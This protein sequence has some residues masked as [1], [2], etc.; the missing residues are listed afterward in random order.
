M[1]PTSAA[2]AVPLPE[3]CDALIVGAGFAGLYMLHKL[4]QLGFDA[5]VVEAGSGVGGTWY[6]NRY[7]GARCDIES[8]QYS[9]AFDRELQQDWEW[10][11]RYAAQPE[12]LRYAEH[13][14]D[15]FALRSGITLNTRVAGADLDEAD[16]S[17]LVR[18]GC[19]AVLRTRYLIAAVGCLSTAQVPPWPGA[20]TFGGQ[21]Y[22]TGAWP[23]EGVDLRGKRVG[24][25]GTGSSGIQ[26]I[27]QL[28][29]HAEH[30][31]VFQRTATYTIPARNRPLRPG[32]LDELKAR[33]PE[34]RRAA[35]ASS[36]G[37]MFTT[38]GRPLLEDPPE[39]QQE[40]LHRYW[41][42][43]GLDIARAYTD[44]PVDRTANAVAS[45]FIRARIAELV[46]DPVKRELLTPRT[47][48]FNSRRPC[49][50][51][52][53]F[54]TFNRPNV[55]LV[56]VRT[57]P[58]VELTPTGLRTESAKHDLDVIV[59]ATGYDAMTGTLKRLNVRG[60]DGLGLADAWADQ[61]STYLGL[62]VH[63]FPNFF[64]LA[65]PGSPSVMSNVVLAIEQ[66]VEWLGDL[67]AHARAVGADEVEAEATAQEAWVRH[68]NEVAARSMLF[69]TDSWYLS[70]NVAGRPRV[71][72]P[73][74]G[75]ADLYRRT[76][77][78]VAADGYRGLRIE[79]RGPA[80]VPAQATERVVSAAG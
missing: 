77:E 9:Y 19:G 60:R 69:D 65:G 30:L 80:E 56:D 57:D 35:R 38:E 22:H 7:P 75:G 72:L 8:V 29:E 17:W 45:E 68:S 74:C 47:Y 12:I 79:R 33:Y 58:I 42:M 40:T 78:E 50:D 36:N 3:S 63:G 5:H 15:R 27:P 62:T 28:A 49:L 59:F 61:P 51:T 13:V 14:A 44:V 16:G 41:D 66:H 76:C 10:S 20:E 37:R 53:Y 34:I 55:D 67:L 54:E 21:T 11:E 71:A 2:P 70:A 23:H 24:V 46:I 25:I 6:W 52:N 4:R 73:Y 32:E 18:T 43:G 64:A 39:L 26:I 31:T 1:S 48:P